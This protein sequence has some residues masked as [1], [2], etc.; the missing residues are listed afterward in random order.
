MN[1]QQ[2]FSYFQS[3]YISRQEVLFKLPLNISIESFWPELLNWR[4]GHA[5]MLPLYTIEGK[6]FW[7]VTT[8][9]MVKAS[10]ALCEEALNTGE[11]F[12]PYRIEMTPAMSQ[13]A[14]FTSYVEGAE[15]PLEEAVA[16][17][18]RGTDPENIYEQ[19]ILNNHQA[20]S[21]MLSSLSVP[22]GEEFVKNLAFYLTEGQID[23]DF[24]YRAE[25]TAVIPAM[26]GDEYEVPAAYTLPE[27]MSQFYGFLGNLSIHPLIKAAVAQ[28]WVFLTRPFPEGN[29]RL[30]RMLSSAILLR[31]GYSYFLDISISANIAHESFRYFKA[32]KEIVRNEKEGDMTYF[33]EYYLCLLQRALT[34]HRESRQQQ[35]REAERKMA[36]QPLAPSPPAVRQP[37]TEVGKS[38]SE[39]SASAQPNEDSEQ[40]DQEDSFEDPPITELSESEIEALIR[41][42]VPIAYAPPD[43]LSEQPGD[44]PQA[45]GS[46]K[47][48]RASPYFPVLID[49]AEMI[50]VQNFVPKMTTL[51][52]MGI[53]RFTS[54]EWGE[55]HLISAEE[56]LADCEALYSAGIADRYLR[57]GR[58]MYLLRFEDSAELAQMVRD[59]KIPAPAAVSKT[60]P[61]DG[62]QD[63]WTRIALMETSRSDAIRRAAGV[64]R[65]MI[66]EGVREFTRESWME[67]TG[68]AYSEFLAAKDKMLASKIVVN[69]A[70]PN[71]VNT[72]RP[73]HFQFTIAVDEGLIQ[74][75]S[76]FS[77]AI[78]CLEE[79]GDI[80]WSSPPEATSVEQVLEGVTEMDDSA[81]SQRV[82]DYLIPRASGDN[83]Y[84]T[85]EDWET[86]FHISRTLAE[87]DIRKAFH[88]GLLEK[89]QSPGHNEMSCYRLTAGPVAA[90]RTHDLSDE[91][92]SHL[93][94]VYDRYRT[95]AF[96]QVD[97]A[98]LLNMKTGSVSYRID[99][100]VDRGIF[101]AGRIGRQSVYRLAITPDDHPECFR[102]EILEPNM[103]ASVV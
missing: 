18:R 92:K 94:M 70:N 58:H 78:R 51:L 39:S 56:A 2:L 97:F 77:E 102:S 98:I 30:A 85:A 40:E 89:E 9:K 14:Y 103:M 62:A 27:R 43:R 34:A 6:P 10:E 7:F 63:F 35:A 84:F 24:D 64:V 79:S 32:M 61:S 19:N 86:H 20:C 21:Y 93:R 28:A 75:E 65:D 36:M 50:P 57:N 67:R 52:D 101:S 41:G 95:N 88:L 80:Q 76:H 68:M 90:L 16:F 53:S 73:G 1:K 38:A 54:L 44:L 49:L 60:D 59:G 42:A 3:H 47:E 13:E 71:G 55:M 46:R 82:R 100:F 22:F 91:K 25:D 37:Q 74:D 15:Y 26:E 4:K 8:D 5:T 96:S 11:D 66:R 17:L 12:D 29:E 69:I 83:D 48:E 81:R 33:V 72:R 87:K 99:E 45:E 23:G 31:S